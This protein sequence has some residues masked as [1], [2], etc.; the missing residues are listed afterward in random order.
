[1]TRE[2]APGQ[3]KKLEGQEL[4]EGVPPDFPEVEDWAPEGRFEPGV[5]FSE[6]GVYTGGPLGPVVPPRFDTPNPFPAA[7]LGTEVLPQPIRGDVDAEEW[8]G[9]AYGIGGGEPNVSHTEI[10][11]Y[12]GQP[13]DV[14]NTNQGEVRLYILPSGRMIFMG[15]QGRVLVVTSKGEFYARDNPYGKFKQVNR[16]PRWVPKEALEYLRGG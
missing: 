5:P 14:F 12:F 10:R 9:E 11:N 2:T 4:I 1:M 16:I 6:A 13:A 15:P 8:L 7:P 3:L